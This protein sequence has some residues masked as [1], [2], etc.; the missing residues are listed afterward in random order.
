MQSMPRFAVSCLTT[1]YPLSTRPASAVATHDVVTPRRNSWT[2]IRIFMRPRR[3]RVLV[4]A[5]R[6]S[7]SDSAVADALP[8]ILTPLPP[9]SES[10]LSTTVALGGRPALTISARSVAA[11]SATDDVSTKPRG[12]GTGGDSERAYCMSASLLRAR[13]WCC[14]G[15]IEQ[16]T[17]AMAAAID[18]PA[19]LCAGAVTAALAAFCSR[20]TACCESGST[21]AGRHSL[22]A[23]RSSSTS[24]D[25]LAAAARAL[26]C[27]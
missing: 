7:E 3:P 27:T 1:Q 21:S 23:C 22:T 4:M 2:S 9:P 18:A 26:K 24:S 20:V 17:H 6:Q 25:A 19:A 14:G 10:L 12:A 13:W 15:E 11:S 5:S 16:R 8:Q